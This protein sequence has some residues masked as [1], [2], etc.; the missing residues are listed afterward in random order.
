VATDNEN[1]T[2]MSSSVSIVVVQ[3]NV[4]AKRWRST[5]PSFGASFAAPRQ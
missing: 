3:P 2:T 5:A 1:A 4:G